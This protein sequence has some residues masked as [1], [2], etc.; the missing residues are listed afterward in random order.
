MPNTPE[1]AYSPSDADIDE[2][3]ATEMG[4]DLSD[5]ALDDEP[6]SPAGEE[7]IDTGD[8]DDDETPGATGDDQPP[9][10]AGAD[11]AA[12]PGD[13]ATGDAGAATAGGPPAPAL[14]EGAKPFTFKAEKQ[15]F[16]FPGIHET[17]EGS[18]I[19]AK[20]SSGQLR[21]FLAEAVAARTRWPQERRTYEK[22][23]KQLEREKT[24]GR[25]AKDVEADAIIAEFERLATLP[26]GELY[27]AVESF[28]ENLPN[29]RLQVEKKKLEH[30]RAEFD[31]QRNGQPATP[32]D[33]EEQL[34]ESLSTEVRSTLD[35]LLA[36]PAAKFLTDEDKAEFRQV[37]TK[38][39]P[40]LLRRATA[41]DPEAGIKKGEVVFDDDDLVNDFRRT[42]RI[43]KD[44]HDRAEAARKADA[45]NRKRNIDQ[46]RAG[47]PLPPV[48]G[49]GSTAGAQE[50]KGPAD[51][52][53]SP[54]AQRRRK[55]RSAREKFLAGELDEPE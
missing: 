32:E 27:G 8:Q 30:D 13:E 25:T 12:K 40:T 1:G 49:R 55:K 31:R 43:R 48:V 52:D 16:A 21:Q 53:D 7:P 45:E 35:K 26:E 18:L 50:R 15:E 17:V 41:D 6:E 33:E 5:D 9:S 3:V 34:Y 46:T 47:N 54:R 42:I 24:E 4:T 51:T 44:A 22:R 14:P 10:G 11:E 29:L 19:V 37:W 36:H 2:M 38:R 23:I 20:E 28:R 39:A